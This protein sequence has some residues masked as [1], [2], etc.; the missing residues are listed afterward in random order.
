ML[1]GANVTPRKGLGARHVRRF[2]Y[3][4]DVLGGSTGAKTLVTPDGLAA[5]IPANA[6]IVSAYIEPLVAATSADSGT[7]KLGITGNDD[8]FIGA[9]AYTDN[10]FDTPGN[11]AALTAEIPLKVGDSDVSVLATIAN[12]L[13]DG[14]FDVVVT[15]DESE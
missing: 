9:T 13:T 11:V 10:K 14:T 4:F 1:V 8:C 7:V 15:W 3:D 2:R 6:V 12:A 5:V